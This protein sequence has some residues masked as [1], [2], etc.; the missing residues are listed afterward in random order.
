MNIQDRNKKRNKIICANTLSRYGL[1]NPNS[2]LE[3]KSIDHKFENFSYSKLNND[4]SHADANIATEA[5]HTNI[6]N[7]VYGRNNQI[8][9]KHSYL[10]N[11]KKIISM[12][13]GIFNM[14]HR[15]QSI[16]RHADLSLYVGQSGRREVQ[17]KQISKN[18]STESFGK[19]PNAPHHMN[20]AVRGV[21]K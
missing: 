19:H 4:L 15:H 16:P 14:S 21:S 6:Y 13:R 20:D 18:L 10:N 3:A 5:S 11:A 2:S 9:S 1:E 17:T 8:E 7:P 12:K